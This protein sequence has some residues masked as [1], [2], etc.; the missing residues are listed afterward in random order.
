MEVLSVYREHN[1]FLGWRTDFLGKTL[2]Q[3]NYHSLETKLLSETADG[4]EDFIS[5]PGRS[6]VTWNI[7][8]AHSFP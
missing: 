4:M 1:G 5:D 7:L 8:V 6:V 3:A 2:L